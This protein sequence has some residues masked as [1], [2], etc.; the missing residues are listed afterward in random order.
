VERLPKKDLYTIGIKIENLLLEIIELTLLAYTKNGAGK[1]L[2]INK[3]DVL[4]RM[5]RLFVRMASELKAMNAQSY[6]TIE[7][8]ALEIGSIIG[9]WMKKVKGL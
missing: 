4:L 8:R 1:M 3:I 6:A 2:I 5:F 7:G 9:G